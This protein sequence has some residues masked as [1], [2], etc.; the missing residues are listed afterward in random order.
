M[1]YISDV[2]DCGNFK[3]HCLNVIA[4]G[5]GTGKTHW[6]I[7]N[8]LRQYPDVLPEEV[9]FVTS[10]TITKRQVARNDGTTLLTGENIE[11]VGDR[12]AGILKDTQEI[13]DMGI[14]VA[15]YNQLAHL[16]MPRDENRDEDE[17][18]AMISDGEIFKKLKILVLDECHVLYSDRFMANICALNV[19]L[20]E[21]IKLR[22]DIV[23]IGLTATPDI[24]RDRSDTY[25][26]RTNFVTPGVL[27]GYKA[28][29]LICCDRNS[30]MSVVRGF[31][32]KTIIMC[33][34]VAD[35]RRYAKFLGNAEIVVSESRQSVVTDDMQE[36]RE[37]I[38]QNESV[39]ET[40]LNRDTGHKE[41]L[42]YLISTSALREGFNLREKSGV[43][44]VVLFVTDYVHV[45]QFAGRCRY[46][47]D[48]LVVV[49]G[50]K[51]SFAETNNDQRIID[52]RENFVRFFTE[53]D[54]TW[55]ESI[56]HIV[57][58]GPQDTKF[59][60]GYS[61]MES[62][63]QWFDNRYLTTPRGKENRGKWIIRKEGAAP[64]VEKA[65]DYHI[66][67]SEAKNYNFNAIRRMLVERYGYVF[68]PGMARDDVGLFRYWVVIG[69]KK[70]A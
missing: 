59:V 31:K 7:H 51:E 17:E 12:L 67:G 37:Y 56:A 23:V 20:R 62:F 26:I 36:L 38:V 30:V 60:T 2:V 5:C 9:L 40:H 48:N 21:Q 52:S 39:P 43:R 66:M 46:N 14:I 11:N 19:F 3:K 68:E 42:R 33:R 65:K 58:H 28:K 34:S 24:L 55:W 4:S 1:R 50:P 6:I 57:Q 13:A 64:V 32:G 15:S 70:V 41:P 35:C 63:L 25:N 45:V 69:K 49:Y 29:Q 10:R 16:I 61:D 22:D 18:P 27:E 8:L 54:D 47:F 53:R 44:N